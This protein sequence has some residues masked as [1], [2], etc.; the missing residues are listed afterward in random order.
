MCGYAQLPGDNQH[1]AGQVDGADL[2]YGDIRDTE[3][4]SALV[5]QARPRT[6]YHLA[7]LSHVGDSWELRRKTLEVNLLGTD[8]VLDAVT[9][10]NRDTK[11]VLVSS[12]QVY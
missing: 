9:Q 1:Q 3:H 10:T 11:V 8:A 12:G 2:H 4:L 6:V 5:A 7:A